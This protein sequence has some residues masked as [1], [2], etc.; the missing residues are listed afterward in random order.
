MDSIEEFNSSTHAMHAIFGCNFTT[1]TIMANG[2]MGKKIF[3]ANNW[4]I[5]NTV[6]G[7]HFEPPLKRIN[8][9]FKC[10]NVQMS[11]C[12][13]VHSNNNVYCLILPLFPSNFNIVDHISNIHRNNSIVQAN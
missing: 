6:F 11:K 1:E 3:R 9:M 4:L 8:W 12:L 13:N 10:P 7:G 2:M 5:L